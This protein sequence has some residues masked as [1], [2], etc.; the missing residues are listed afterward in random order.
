M[1]DEE[2]KTLLTR[3]WKALTE[4]KVDTTDSRSVLRYEKLAKLFLTLSKGMA[5]AQVNE[6]H[7]ELELR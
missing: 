5:A 4:S 7:N 3:T 6:E 1:H 2:K